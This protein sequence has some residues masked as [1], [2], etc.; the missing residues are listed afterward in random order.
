MD[1]TA[2]KMQWYGGGRWM[3]KQVAETWLILPVSCG[4]L[5]NYYLL[6]LVNPLEQSSKLRREKAHSSEGL[7][8]F[9]FNNDEPRAGS[10]RKRRRKDGR[11]KTKKKKNLWSLWAKNGDDIDILVFTVKMSP[12]YYL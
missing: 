2:E 8:S 7:S 12:S 4:H 9:N 6:C 3:S 10:L 1:L 5:S 11:N